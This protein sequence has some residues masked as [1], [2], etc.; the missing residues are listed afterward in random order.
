LELRRV[1][2][3]I[4]NFQ[5]TARSRPELCSELKS[6]SFQEEM[7]KMMLRYKRKGKDPYSGVQTG[8][9]PL[10]SLVCYRRTSG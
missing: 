1:E 4:I 6:G 5:H 9:S 10:T 7:F 8:P 3:Y 2:R